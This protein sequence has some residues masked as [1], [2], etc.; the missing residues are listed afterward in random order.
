M[1][2]LHQPAALTS[3]CRLGP[4]THARATAN[5]LEIKAAD[6]LSGT[7]PP[8]QF[9]VVKNYSLVRPKQHVLIILLEY[10]SAHQFAILVVDQASQLD[11]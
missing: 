4:R 8:R 11:F 9:F 7:G 5:F 6:S 1:T 2:S 10:C 3:A